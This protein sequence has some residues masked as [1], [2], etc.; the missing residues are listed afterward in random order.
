MEY[1][2]QANLRLEDAILTLLLLLYSVWQSEESVIQDFETVIE[3]VLTKV[4]FVFRV[5]TKYEEGNSVEATVSNS[6]ACP[7][8][9]LTGAGRPVIVI[10][11]EQ[12]EFLRELHF[13]RVKS[14]V[15]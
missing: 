6:F 13:S 14:L 12:N 15:C 10:E 7:T 11:R 9:K 4:R 5:L 8:T 1:F 2:E 3:A